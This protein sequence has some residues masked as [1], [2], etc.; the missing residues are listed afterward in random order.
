MVLAIFL[1]I[2]ATIGLLLYALKQYI[3]IFYT[4]T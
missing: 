1:G 3:D 4:T 2:S